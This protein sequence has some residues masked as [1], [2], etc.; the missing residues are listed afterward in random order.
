[1]KLRGLA[2]A[3][4]G[5]VIIAAVS[6]AGDWIWATWIPRHRPIYG[7]THGSILFLCVGLFLGALS[8]RHLLGAAAGAI[9]G[10]LGAAAFYVLRPVTGY[11]AMFV[12]WFA[13]WIALGF[14]RAQLNKRSTPTQSTSASRA[15]VQGVVAAMLS[16][17][18][19]YLVSGIWSPFN[20]T[21]LDYVVH[22]AAWV[23]AYLPGFAA[24]LV[25][26]ES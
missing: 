2:S 17:I 16:G 15:V 11:A 20:P 21:G 4:T 22:F 10:F 6:T 5:A 1:M 19:F 24:L 12:A 13:I 7:I 23:V 3:F 26:K 18:A 14:L 25:E 8:K 9:I